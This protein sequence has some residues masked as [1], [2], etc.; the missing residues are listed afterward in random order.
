MKDYQTGQNT[1]TNLMQKDNFDK[2][3]SK[4][5]FKLTLIDNKFCTK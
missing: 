4:V 1:I 3:S 5:I 2:E